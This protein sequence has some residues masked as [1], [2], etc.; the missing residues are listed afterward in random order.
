MSYTSKY[1]EELRK[2][3][4]V[5]DDYEAGDDYTR[6]YL[7]VLNEI[8]PLPV[9]PTPL[10][11]STPKASQKPAK[12][13]EKVDFFKKGGLFKDGYDFGDIW[14]TAGL[15]FSDAALSILEGIGGMA[16][17]VLDL[18]G[19]IV[20]GGAD[21]VG[22]DNFADDLRKVVNHNTVSE[23]AEWI[24]DIGGEGGIGEG[25]VLGRTTR[26]VGQGVGQI[27]GILLTGGLGSA[28]G[29]GAVGTTALTSGTMFASS[30][31]AGVSEAYNDGAS[32]AEAWAYGTIK[33]G[34]D[35]ASELIFGGLGKGVKALGVSHGLSSADDILAKK[36]SS[37]IS[38]KVAKTFVQAGVKASGEGL[39][40]VLAGLGTAAAK[41]I[42]KDGVSYQEL[43]EDENLLEQ[44]VVGALSSG[45]AQ[46][47]GVVNSVKTGTDFIS[48]MTAN[49]E[50]VVNKEVEKRIAQE[51]ESGNKLSNKEKNAIY[52]AVVNDMDKG[53]ISTDTIEEALGGDTFKAYQDAIKS[54]EAV[55]NE[56]ETLGKKE[57]PTLADQARYAE[58]TKQIEEQKANPKSKALKQQLS[59]TTF[60]LAK[61]SR[62]VETY[63]EQTRR[64]QAFQADLTK[65]DAKQAE[66]VKKAIDSGILNN[67]NRTHEF[68]DLVAK[69]SADKGVS[70][71]FANNAKIKES[72]FAV[73]GATVNGFVTDSGITVN[74]QSAKA[75]NTVVGHEI[76]HILEGTELY[77]GLQKAVVEYAKT[78]GEY[79]SRL[80]A[81]TKLYEG[82]NADVNKELVADLVGDYLF[83]DSDFIAR[84]ST[85]NRNVFQ[86]IYDE[87]KYL[88]KVA[89]AGSKE[90]RQLEKAKRAFEKVYKESKADGKKAD[91]NIEKHTIIEDGVKY[92]IT[93]NSEITIT[94]EQKN[95]NIQ[96]VA[97]MDSVYAVDKS[98]L[99]NSGRDLKEIYAEYFDAWGGNIYSN[100]FGD[101][102]VKASSIRSEIRHG[103]TAE[104]IAAIEA[105]PSVIEQGKI[106]DWIE[107]APGL[108]RVVVAAPIKIGDSSYFMGVML[109]R[110][111]QNQ[112]L[113]L[114]DVVIEKETSDISQEHL[115]TT[116]PYA[117]NGNLFT[118]NILE[119]I[120]SVKVQSANKGKTSNKK[121]SIS[122][123][124][125]G[126]KLTKGQQEYF[127]DSKVVD[128]DGNLKVM[129]HGSNAQF[130]SFDRSKAKGSGLYG[131]GF[132]FT[133][134]DTHAKTYG[135]LY[136]VYLNIRNPLKYGETTVSRDQVRDFLNAVA[137]NED[138]SI[139]NYGTY[140][141]EEVL[142]TVMGKASNV[143]AFQIIQDI[144]ATAI[145]DMVEAAE[146]FNS[147]NGTSF[148]GIVVPT[149]TVAFYPEQIKSTANTNPTA[150]TDI[151]YS[152]SADTDRA[153]LDA[154]KR[155]DMETAQKMVNEAAEAAGYTTDTSWKMQHSAPNS[156]YDVSLAD[157]KESGLV[158]DDYWTHP[159]WYTSSAEERE[160]FYKVRSAIELQERL[161]ASGKQHRNAYITVYR[162]VDKTKNTKEEAIRNGDWVTPSRDYAVNEGLDNPNGYRIIAQRVPIKDLYWDG[163]SIAELGYDDGNTYAYADTKN[164]RKL[165]DAVTYDEFDQVIP[166]S[167]RFNK[168][169]WE[170]EYS[171]SAEGSTQKQYGNYNVYGKDIALQEDIAPVR[172]DIQPKAQTAEE[173]FPDDLGPIADDTQQRLWSM[174]DEDAPPEIAPVT[175]S[176]PSEVADPFAAKDIKEVGQRNVKPF[177][178]ENPDIK[179]FFQAEAN[180]LLG[181]L[182]RT[183]KGKRY[184]SEEGGYT[185]TSRHTSEDVAYL[186]DELKLS[187]KDIEASLKA[188]ISGDGNINRAA[189]KRIEFIINDRLMKGYT[190]FE[191]GAYVQ[192]NQQ[193]INA[194]NQMQQMEAFQDSIDSLMEIADDIAPARETRQNLKAEI[195]IEHLAERPETIEEKKPIL[196]V[197]QRIEAK[198]K[199]LQSELAEIERQRQ[200]SWKSFDEDIKG[201]KEQ[202]NGKAKKNT[203]TA[204]NLLIRIERTETRKQNTDDLYNKRINSVKEKIAKVQEEIKTGESP[205]EQAAMRVE[206]HEKI[207]DNI[208]TSFAENGFDFDEVLADAKDL[209]TIST[210]DNTPQRVLEK[211]LGYK[212]GKVLADLTVNKVAENE[213]KAIRWLNSITDRK[214]GLLAQLSKQY[215]IKPGS[216]ESAAAQMYAEGYY[217]VYNGKIAQGDDIGKGELVKYGDAELA[218]DFPDAEVRKNIKGLARDPRIREF[219]DAAL[220]AINEA[221]TRNAYPE[222]KPLKNYFLHFRAQTDA[223]S[224]LGIPFNPKEIKAKDLPTDLNGVTADLKPGQPFFSSS[225]HRMGK[226]TSFDLLGGLEQYAAGASRQIFHI[227]DIQTLRALRNYVADI[228][229]QAKGFEKLDLLEEDEAQA[230]VEGIRKAHL[231]TFAKFLNEEANVIAGKT[232]LTDRAIE[233][234]IGREGLTI[235]DT[236]NRQVGAN[237]VGFNVSSS[238]T[239]LI[240]PVQAFAKS[241][242]AAFV[243]AMAQ[244]A[245]NRLKSIKGQSDGFMEN[246]PVAIRRKG[247]DRFA[248]TPWAKATDVSYML[249]SAVDSV[250]TELIA[251]AK[252][253]ELTKKGMDSEQAHIE[254]DKWV[255]RL[256]GDR[257]L[258]QQPQLYNSKMLGMFTKF[259][260][261]VR[262]QLDAQFYDTIQEAK[263]SNEE[264]KNKL[265][266]NAKTAAKVTKTFVE[267]AVLQHLFGKVFESVAGYN[268][269][270]DIISA[271]IKTFGFDDDEEDDDTIADNIGEGLA[272]LVG[273]LP[274]T[275]LITDGGRIPIASA[276]TEP[277]SRILSGKDKY[278]NDQPFLKN[279]LN[280]IATAAPYYMLPGGY[281]QL[282][283][284]S[285]GLGMF[286]DDLP[287]AGSYTDSGNL[288]FPVAPTLPNI[289]QAAVFGQYAS[290]NARDYFDNEYA[291]LKEKQIQ[292]FI[293]LDIPIKDYRDIREGLKGKDTLG[294]KVAY[295][296][297]LDLPIDKKNIL[298]NNAAN[299]EEPIDMSDYGE[300]TDW[301]EFDYAKKYP[302]KYAFL[303]A[304]NITVKQYNKFDDETK[305]AWSWAYQNP[306]KFALS[307]S[308][309][310]DVVK[311]R[312]YT[313]ALSDISA[314]KD[315]NG[316]SISGSRKE[317]VISYIN[318]LDADYGEKII[319]FKSEYPADDTYNYE[320]VEYL[321]SR[322]DIT[323]DEMITILYELGFTVKNGRAYWD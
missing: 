154:V 317:K 34:V 141:V 277:A 229:G 134:S 135:N 81:I 239:N 19:H 215:K 236:I 4:G 140:D 13:E 116:G 123:D 105:I 22:A 300:Y 20:A 33:G 303:K 36:L 291:P 181:E 42:Y 273:D 221:R 37:K 6:E 193:Y 63:N 238:L 97:E 7:K 80:A 94:E 8:A 58:L 148:D 299:R 29:L 10:E 99:E 57:N 222:I 248:R 289:A 9:Q 161:V 169:K 201:L 288:R 220:K 147:I 107:K 184:Y 90:A 53:Y 24:R 28:A 150:D 323:Y 110:D 167:K 38:S 2:L 287:I 84:L 281:G 73:D 183:V 254:T 243:K 111:S 43:L 126:N 121:Y 241:N 198:L 172:E 276:T 309:A 223:F 182:E 316:K 74:I 27:G 219:Y 15:T 212:E 208:K 79:D 234:I 157:I 232:A 272:E 186:L 117:E 263:L 112:R 39:E 188:I 41:M 306:E 159:E 242:K 91:A 178:S 249:M 321:G 207:I 257:S 174:T 21:L 209:R 62:L 318:N 176:I 280:E 115:V 227:D 194:L 152:I 310:S 78:K 104:K 133:D 120:A 89:T 35:A 270:F 200:E 153:Y 296:A 160:S 216:K 67:T 262:N 68:V 269:A 179:P 51:E 40:E 124:T 122:A 302:D 185:G 101:I 103:T 170:T 304:N 166:L 114:H 195:P 98:K 163:N 191:T 314:D 156:K 137:E 214:N 82:K 139:E 218:R 144:N 177:M 88:A 265:A 196:N 313:K 297:T 100:V 245:S 85:E 322:E 52:D 162:A 320:I 267:L 190:D 132:Y 143:D 75:L 151:R 92:S 14:R 206:V 69:I 312:S 65:Y 87:I 187:Y 308:I 282:K 203:Q 255:S 213:T 171:V 252:Y 145:G 61:D 285:Q 298:V 240:A 5:T 319:L 96:E 192:P 125:E 250:S 279:A 77:D 225:M 301:G 30:T 64:T 259:Q 149:E 247:A 130:T 56:F 113:Y 266:R 286:D 235:L 70:F 86:K 205:K 197:K 233:G 284:T 129:Y 76:T 66:V 31:G 180:N 168:R 164:N 55:K 278:G 93:S 108:F 136:S 18:G 146:L 12:K 32:D 59:E 274:Y 237:M 138:Y 60:N 45:L 294:E 189:I 293:D 47:G 3:R 275:S 11:Q 295:I 258:G 1:L 95:A 230:R 226:R 119:K 264:I 54:E 165:L 175:D 246:S 231:S 217:E 244:T 23:A 128:A 118:T 261:E 290:K 102:A 256:M 268:P 46:S 271:I 142:N 292:E 260:L 307:K 25:S 305:E 26:G 109:Q 71:D 44:F 17:G 224:R 199:N 83:T 158:P 283:K 202:Y 251:R 173:M 49:E 253:N 72:G 131:K 127:K 228:Y 16:E 210:V 106:V 315:E 311:Y 204:N 48:G 211:S 155:G 50:T